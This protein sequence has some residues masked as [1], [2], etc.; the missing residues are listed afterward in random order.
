MQNAKEKTNNKS[1]IAIRN[2]NQK[3]T[4]RQKSQG[5]SKTPDAYDFMCTRNVYM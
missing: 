3:K 2:K 1:C 4:D 5:I